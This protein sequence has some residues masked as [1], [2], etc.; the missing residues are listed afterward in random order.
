MQSGLTL[1]GADFLDSGFSFFKDSTHPQVRGRFSFLFSLFFCCGQ[2]HFCLVQLRP[3]LQIPIRCNN[4]YWQRFKL[5]SKSKWKSRRRLS[6]NMHRTSFT[7]SWLRRSS[8]APPSLSLS[9]CLSHSVILSL[10]DF[11]LI[12]HTKL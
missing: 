12:V 10:H 5:S 6:F 1:L 2:V 3:R 11:W 4:S 7:V 8:L 9:L